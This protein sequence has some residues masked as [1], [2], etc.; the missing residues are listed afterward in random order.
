MAE[1]GDD[2]DERFRALLDMAA[3]VVVA[4]RADH[5]V[6]EWNEAATRLFGV[7]RE[8]ALGSNYVQRFLPPEQREPVSE[9]IR[10]VLSGTPTYGYEDDAVLPDGTRRT[11]LWNVT[12]LLSEGGN[13]EGILAMGQDITERKIAERRFRQMFERSADGILLMRVPSGVVECNAA[14]LDMLGLASNE[15]LRNVHLVEFSPELQPD[16]EPSAAKSRRMDAIAE[17]TGFHR[18]EWMH[19]DVHK[20][21]LPVE[22]SLSYLGQ[23][24]GEPLFLVT[25]HDLRPR[26]RAEAERERLE[27]RLR[28]A[29]RLEVV[30]RF[31]G[32]IAHDF[33]NILTVVQGNVGFLKDELEEVTLPSGAEARELL[34]EI[35]TV[36]DRARAL[37]RQLLAFS[38][39]QP[40]EP[41][42]VVL[43]ELVRTTERLLRR[44][45]GD[46]IQLE[47]EVKDE[48]AAVR[49]D[50]GQLEQVLLNLALNG[51]DAMLDSVDGS[52]GRGGT[53][54]V[55]VDRPREGAFVRLSVQDGGHGMGSETQARAFEPFFTTKPFGKGSGLGLSTV[56]GI[57]EQAGGEVTLESA[58]GK[59]TTVHVLLPLCGETPSDAEELRSDV[60]SHLPEH[61]GARV[62]LVEDED[63]VRR[64]TR[65][66]LVR[67]GHAVETARNGVLG[68]ERWRAE[69]GGFDVV[70]TDIRMPELSG[71]ELATRLLGERPGQPIVFLTGFAADGI[72]EDVARHARVVHKPFR[73]SELLEAIDAV[74]RPR[75]A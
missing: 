21:P 62:L 25:W 46:E 23:E 65:R 44:L 15:G 63:A 68:L 45:I 48:Q 18:F 36:G 28:H 41:A 31:A 9:D 27:T 47:V 54:R 43:A 6:F 3:N 66:V 40:I 51:R 24:G 30:G 71:I 38:R 16:G 33:N 13:V 53:L 1:P 17:E 50:R 35:A 39:Q 72:P 56:H 59:G 61:V 19:Q 64:T 7:S 20:Q 2:S 70:V 32:G 69:E 29:E 49:A 73:T 11:M 12:R 57:V 58:P 60:P 10:K 37:V 8:D 22:V 52:P 42:R 4:L 34:E 67:A 74:L 5:T 14:A 55:V 26:K 75:G